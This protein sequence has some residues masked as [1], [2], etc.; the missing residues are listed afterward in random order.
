M[1]V[2]W[3]GLADMHKREVIYL[4]WKTIYENIMTTNKERQ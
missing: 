3:F 2:D 4:A 1:V